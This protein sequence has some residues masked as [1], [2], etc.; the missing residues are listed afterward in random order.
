MT[1]HP[2]P[3]TRALLSV[4]DKSGLI[5]FARALY[6]SCVCIR[7]LSYFTP[8]AAGNTTRRDLIYCGMSFQ[9]VF[10]NGL[11]LQQERKALVTRKYFTPLSTRIRHKG[12]RGG[13]FEFL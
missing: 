2:R 1:D 3:V 13:C 6:D 11:K 12:K 9:S 5:E 8:Q 10:C 4:S 7:S